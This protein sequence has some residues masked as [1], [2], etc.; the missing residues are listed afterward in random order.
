MRGDDLLARTFEWLSAG[1]ELVPKDAEGIDVAPVVNH[2][3]RR[4]LGRHVCRCADHDTRAGDGLIVGDVCGNRSRDAEVREEHVVARQEDVV[5]FDVAMRD[6]G[7]MRV[8]QRV[9]KLVEDSDRFT[10]RQRAGTQA[11]AE[12]FAVDERH[13]VER[14]PVDGARSRRAAECADA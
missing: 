5:R 10:N 9:G 7:R 1:Q 13:D 12:R 11:A 3:G 14:Q 4:L 6:P 8:G 2:S